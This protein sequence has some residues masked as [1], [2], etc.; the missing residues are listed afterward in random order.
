L[1][2]AKQNSFGRAASLRSRR[3]I[4]YITFGRSSAPL[5][6]HSRPSVVP[7]LS[8]SQKKKRCFDIEAAFFFWAQENKFGI[9]LTKY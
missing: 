5:V 7:L 9:W 8:L 3:A 2:F 4:R 6:R 1:N